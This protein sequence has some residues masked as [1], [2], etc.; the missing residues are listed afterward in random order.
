LLLPGSSS[1]SFS[2]ADK[3]EKANGGASA[4][5]GSSEDQDSSRNES[6]QRSF[7]ELWTDEELFDSDSFLQATQAMADASASQTSTPNR[8]RTRSVTTRTSFEVPDITS[9]VSSKSSPMRKRPCFKQIQGLTTM[10]QTEKSPTLEN[11]SIT[12]DLLATLAEPDDILDSQV[13][14]SNAPLSSQVE[15]AGL[16]SKEDLAV[17]KSILTMFGKIELMADHPFK[18]TEECELVGPSQM[19]ASIQH[20]KGLCSVYF[21]MLIISNPF[22]C[23]LIM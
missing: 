18:G 10:V 5:Q 2:F 16:F 13:V 9:P 8:P 19:L 22:L 4:E 1:G 23:N 15:T 6:L 11:T 20:D 21:S 12:E 7:E 3:M 17:G 14:C